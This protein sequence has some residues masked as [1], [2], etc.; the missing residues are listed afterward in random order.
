MNRAAQNERFASSLADP[1]WDWA[2]TAV[3]YAGVHYVEAYFA[4]LR[5]P[6]HSGTHGARDSD[7][8]R[9]SILNPAWRTYKQMKEDSE[10]ARYE[11]H[12]PFDANNLAKQWTRLNDLKKV[13]QHHL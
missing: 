9:D 10:D 5:P 7:I 6:I 3:Y 13:V 11:P 2:V 4:A 8:R 1:Y 12:I